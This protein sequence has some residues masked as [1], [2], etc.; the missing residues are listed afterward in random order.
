M[1]RKA[2]VMSVDP[3]VS[4]PSTKSGTGR[5]LARAPEA[6]LRSH[7]V[8]NYSIHLDESTHQLFG[9]AEIESEERWAAIAKTE[10]CRKWWQY[11]KDIMPSNPDG[12]PIAHDLREVFYLE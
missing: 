7:G 2:F 1:I 9:Y 3:E 4:T 5:D 11:M 12:S 10:I 6:T 8:H